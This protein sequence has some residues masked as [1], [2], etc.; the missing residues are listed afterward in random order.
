[1]KHLF[2]SLFL[3]FAAAMT[4]CLSCRIEPVFTTD[5]SKKLTFSTDTLRFDTVFTQVGSATRLIKLYNPNKEWIRVSKVYVEGNAGSIFNINVDGVPGNAE[6]IEIAPNDSLYVFARVTINPNQPLSASPFVIE[7]KIIVET[8]GNKQSVLLEA[9]GQNANYIPNRFFKGKLAK[10]SDD[11]TW[12]DPKP[13]IIYGVLFVD[14][15]TLTIPAGAKIYVHGG[16][17]KNK[18]LK[19]TYNDG[20]LWAINGGTI[21]VKGTADKPVIFQTDRL[22]KEFDKV[23]AQWFGIRLGEN[24]HGEFSYTTIKN[25]LVGI[26]AEKDADLKMDNCRIYNVGSSGLAAVHATLDVSNTLIHSSGSNAVILTYGGNYTFTHCTIAA[27]GTESSALSMDNVTCLKKDGNGN[28]IEFDG[29]L[30]NSNFENCIIYGSHKDEIQLLDA[31]D[32]LANA[33]EYQF[34]NCVVRVDELLGVKYHPDFLTNHCKDCINATSVSKL[35]KDENKDD[36]HLDSL[37]VAKDKALPNALFPK[38]LDG[39]ERV[40]LPDIGCFEFKPK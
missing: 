7:D 32:I 38:D 18:E 33:F 4:L 5:A 15:C 30:L 29:N 9:W 27:Y 20:F 40:G 14:A 22:E 10:L 11:Q 26:Y 23:P 31:K 36:Y 16:I 39:V 3:L 17:T 13:Y 19:A 37:S 28:C 1:M 6:N 24:S 34:T 2:C 25:S 35:F 8:N 12:D 21:K